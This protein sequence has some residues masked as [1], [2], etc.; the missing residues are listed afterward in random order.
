MKRCLRAVGASRVNRRQPIPIS[1]GEWKRLAVFGA[2]A[3][4]MG[5]SVAGGAVFGHV[6]DGFFHTDPVL[7]LVFLLV[8]CVGGVVNFIKLYNLFRR[9]FEKKE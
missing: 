8:G 6:L 5:L 3:M 1:P 7:T 2:L 4:E 9:K